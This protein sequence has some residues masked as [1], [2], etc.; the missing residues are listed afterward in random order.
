M[1]GKSQSQL[2]EIFCSIL[3]KSSKGVV[4]SVVVRKYLEEANRDHQ[5]SRQIFERLSGDLI[6][7]VVSKTM[8]RYETIQFITST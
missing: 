6:S 4:A 1:T 8:L 7:A 2:T 3:V 5:L